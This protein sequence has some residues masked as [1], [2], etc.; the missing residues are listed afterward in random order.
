MLLAFEGPAKRAV[1]ETA[2]QDGPV[3]ELPVLAILR[4]T[5]LSVDVH[6][7]VS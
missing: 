4:A 2:L 7:S 5:T 1:L 3:T 6:W